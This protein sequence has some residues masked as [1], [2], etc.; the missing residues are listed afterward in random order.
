MWWFYGVIA[1]SVAAL[2]VALIWLILKAVEVVKSINRVLQTVDESMRATVFE[3][4]ENLRN[5]KQMTGDL[6]SVTGDIKALS[7]S[8]REVGENVKYV[9][10]G[11]KRIT[12]LVQSLGSE[13]VSTISGVRAGIKS[14]IDGF[15]KN[16][17]RSPGK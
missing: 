1:L 15:F 2:T 13:A 16:L 3:V 14:G 5:V 4:N 7:A 10:G 6:T 17:F 8:I 11:I 12:N 9:G